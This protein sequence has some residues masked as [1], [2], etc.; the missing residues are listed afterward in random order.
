MA[1]LKLLYEF[2]MK[3]L[4]RDFC[5]RGLKAI[6]KKE[7]LQARL[8][9]EL[10]EEGEEPNTYLFK[11]EPDVR[12]L[13][14]TFQEQMLAGFQNVI[15]GDLQKETEEEE[16]EHVYIATEACAADVPDMSAPISQ[17]EQDNVVS[18]PK[19]V[20]EDIKDICQFTS[21]DEINSNPDGCTQMFGTN[22][23]CRAITLLCPCSS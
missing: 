21:A 4:R 22:F 13:L 14:I 3:E 18:Y 15:N 5:D 20:A 16:R 6:G 17:I 11:V 8:R 2:E 19:P 1:R 12:E 7:T 9:E 10:I 23:T